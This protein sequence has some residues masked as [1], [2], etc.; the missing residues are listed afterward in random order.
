VHAK[1][2]HNFRFDI[3]VRGAGQIGGKQR[4]LSLMSA[5][6]LV[7]AL[8]FRPMRRDD[9]RLWQRELTFAPPAKSQRR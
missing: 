4:L 5:E 7:C 8:S 6:R 3:E 9:L 1:G 2:R